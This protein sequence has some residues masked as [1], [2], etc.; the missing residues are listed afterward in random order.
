[1]VLD[2]WLIQ[3]YKWFTVGPLRIVF[4]GL[5]GFNVVADRCRE[6][7][8]L[9]APTPH[10]I[11]WN[12]K[13]KTSFRP[14]KHMDD[15][16]YRRQSP[17]GHLIVIFSQL[18]VEKRWGKGLGT[19]NAP[20][21]SDSMP[22]ADKADLLGAGASCPAVDFTHMTQ[23]RLISAVFFFLGLQVRLLHRC[24]ISFFIFLWLV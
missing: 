17:P 2:P 21:A 6:N 9:A 16:R 5:C 13:S 24:V 7:I 1:M 8:H 14:Q 18:S 11:P 23:K 10:W 3:D 15:K 22:A 19:G 12:I 4:S 20:V